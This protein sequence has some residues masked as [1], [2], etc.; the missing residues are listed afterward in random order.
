MWRCAASVNALS[1]VG[2]YRRPPW[3]GPTSDSD[4]W[5][6]LGGLRRYSR[7]LLALSGGELA[8]VEVG[9]EAARR[10]QLLV[11]AL[12]DDGAVIHDQYPVGVANGRE[13]VGDDKAGPPP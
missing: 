2:P 3:A 9:V 6:I 4:C 8:V 5:A 10:Q 13:A 12:F 7:A 1:L 11:R